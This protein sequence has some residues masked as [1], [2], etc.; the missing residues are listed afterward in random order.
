MGRILV[1]EDDEDLRDLLGSTIRKA[2]YQVIT[3]DGGRAC[4]RKTIDEKPDL[5][6]LDIMLPDLAG[7][8][9]CRRLRS[10]GATAA[11]PIIVLSAKSEEADR[12]LGLEV[13]ADDYVTK[14]FSPRELVVRI[15]KVLERTRGRTMMSD[16]VTAGELVLDRAAYLLLFRGNE[17][18]LTRTEFK[19]L[20]LLM[21]R[22]GRV[23]TRE[24]LLA[25]VW[26]YDTSMDTRTVDTHVQRL[27]GKL[28]EAG[29]YIETVRGFGYRLV[30]PS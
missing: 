9:V 30:V 7:T 11:T 25:E 6:L 28:G 4:L 23:Q 20:G 19:L 18:R 16:H 22:C 14:P 21:D 2:G 15:G 10:D 24:R 17:V 5:I 12:I 27:R 1:V 8:D 29:K 26:E 3:A 13:G